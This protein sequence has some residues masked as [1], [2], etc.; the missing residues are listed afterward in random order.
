[1]CAYMHTS[2][3]QKDEPLH[4]RCTGVNALVYVH[5]WRH[6]C[7]C[8]IQMPKGLSCGKEVQLYVPLCFRG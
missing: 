4:L 8:Q 6:Y 7:N 1:M 5:V 2:V 3:G